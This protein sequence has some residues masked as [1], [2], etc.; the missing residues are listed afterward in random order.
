MGHALTNPAAVIKKKTGWELPPLIRAPH[1]TINKTI[2]RI[3]DRSTPGPRFPTTLPELTKWL[4]DTRVPDDQMEYVLGAD[5]EQIKEWRV[6]VWPAMYRDGRRAVVGTLYDVPGSEVLMD[7]MRRVHAEGAP[8]FPVKNVKTVHW[9][10]VGNDW[11]PKQYSSLKSRPIWQRIKITSPKMKEI[12]RVWMRETGSVY[13]TGMHKW[14]RYLAV[15]DRSR[16]CAPPILREVHR[17]ALQ[18]GLRLKGRLHLEHRRIWEE[19]DSIYWDV[20]IVSTEDT[21]EFLPRAVVV[22][23]DRPPIV[24]PVPP[25]RPPC[26]AVE[27]EP[28][29]WWRYEGGL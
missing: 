26:V 8:A 6:K 27:V 2:D 28:E 7:A 11:T 19:G 3:I 21:V 5:C 17:V 9:Q 4:K 22:E 14:M 10:F 15:G 1:K 12:A 18:C 25:G 23:L 13:N 24:V 29:L 20:D 16:K